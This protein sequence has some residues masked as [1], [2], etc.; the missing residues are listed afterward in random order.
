MFVTI[1]FTTTDLGF[2]QVISQAGFAGI[3]TGEAIRKTAMVGLVRLDEADRLT[4]PISP[5]CTSRVQVTAKHNF[6]HDVKFERQQEHV[7]VTQGIYRSQDTIYRKYLATVIDHIRGELMHD[8]ELIEALLLSM[9]NTLCLQILPTPWLP[10]M[11][12]LGDWHPSTA[13]ESHMF[14]RFQLGGKSL[15][16]TRLALGSLPLASGMLAAN[17]SPVCM[18]TSHPQYASDMVSS[19]LSFFHDK[20]L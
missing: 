20:T 8:H 19:S 11:V 13:D 2:S 7:L 5:T 14:G 12:H 6:T 1:L 16:L 15:L 9:S 3:V 17:P 18:C 10:G 4:F